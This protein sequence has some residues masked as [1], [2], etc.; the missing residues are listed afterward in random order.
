MASTACTMRG[1]IADSATRR[2]F[3][4]PVLMSA[5]SSGASSVTRGTGASSTSR[6]DTRSTVATGRAGVAG[7]LGLLEIHADE[8]AL[9]RAVPGQ[10][11]DGAAAD[12]ELAGF[13]DARALRV[14]QVVEPVD[15]LVIAERLALVQLERAARRRAAARDR[16]RRAGARRSAGRR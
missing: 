5:V 4:R 7:R 10:Q 2:R 15:E 8:P 11:H 16:A 13:L 9:G 1:G 6:P 14:A 12:G 3:S